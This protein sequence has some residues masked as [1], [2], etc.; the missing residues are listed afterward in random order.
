MFLKKI[1]K[2]P[3]RNSRKAVYMNIL[4]LYP[5]KNYYKIKQNVRS[6][7]SESINY[8]FLR[9]QISNKTS[10]F[11]LSSKSIISD[12]KEIQKKN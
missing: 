1:N 4:Q 6:C 7:K 5:E 11:Q 8:N 2:N 9:A 12:V 3:Y 10:N